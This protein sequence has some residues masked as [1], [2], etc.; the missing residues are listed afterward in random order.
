MPSVSVDLLIRTQ[1]FCFLRERA[2]AIA[3]T[4]N[5][6]RRSRGELAAKFFAIGRSEKKFYSC[7]KVETPG[8]IFAKKT[9]LT[10][11]WNNFTK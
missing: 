9:L 10:R 11:E 8:N 4:G 3:T 5:N 6:A 7:K 1:V 2:V